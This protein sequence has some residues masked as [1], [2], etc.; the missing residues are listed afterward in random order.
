MN[1]RNAL[2]VSLMLAAVVG[3]VSTTSSEVL[4]ALAPAPAVPSPIM[5]DA[6]TCAQRWERS[7]VWIAKHGLK[8]IQ[9]ATDVQI[10][11]FAPVGNLTE[12]QG[13]GFTALKEPVDRGRYRIS[14]SMTCGSSGDFVACTP[15][16]V[17]VQ[18]AFYHYVETGTDLLEGVHSL[19]G[20]HQ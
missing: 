2:S 17:D 6:S 4:V 18:R 9:I 7:Q 1:R 8:K 19:G 5:C 10:A 20:I 16:P 12:R 13:Y 15:R 11:T 14:L 3:C